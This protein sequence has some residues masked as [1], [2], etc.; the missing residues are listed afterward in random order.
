MLLPV[1]SHVVPAMVASAVADVAFVVMV[2]LS[3]EVAAGGG[4][5]VP[6]PVL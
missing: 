6:V 2:D 3:V 4:V 1:P 5:P